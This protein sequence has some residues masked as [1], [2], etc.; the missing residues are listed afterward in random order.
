MN[1]APQISYAASSLT[2]YMVVS[3]L[4]HLEV[5]KQV[6]RYLRGVRSDMIRWCACDVSSTHAVG[7]VYGYADASFADNSTNRKSTLAYFVFVCF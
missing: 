3:T 4:A 6:L 5:A 1:T 7:E 2:G